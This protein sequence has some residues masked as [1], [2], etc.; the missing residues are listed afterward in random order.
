M[1]ILIEALNMVGVSGLIVCAG[2]PVAFLDKAAD[3]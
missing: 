3:F 2:A 1:F